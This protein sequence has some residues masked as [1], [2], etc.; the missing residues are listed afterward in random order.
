MKKFLLSLVFPFGIVIL[1]FVF[2]ELRKNDYHFSMEV[3]IS[4]LKYIFSGLIVTVFL[5]LIFYIYLL[6]RKKFKQKS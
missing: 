4:I 6:L 1:V 2:S 3:L 5:A